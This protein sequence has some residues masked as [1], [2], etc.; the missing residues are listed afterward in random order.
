MQLSKKFVASIPHWYMRGRAIYAVIGEGRQIV[1]ENSGMFR[2]DHR[3]SD[4]TTISVRAN[5]DEA[6]SN[7]PLASSGQYLQG[8]Q[9]LTFSPVNS[10]IELLHVFSSTLVHEFKFGFNR[11]TVDTD[12]INQTAVLYAFAVSGFTTLNNNKQSM[13]TGN[14]LSEI[15]NVTWVKGRHTAKAGAEIRRIQLNQGNTASGTVNFASQAAFAANQVST[16]TLTGVLP[17]N[18]LRKTQYFG[19]LQ[20]EFKW[21]PNLTVNLGARYSFFNIFHEVLANYRSFPP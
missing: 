3:F 7:A 14:S 19:Y 1:S 11:S 8:Q 17:V 12:N 16:A 13:G 2:I 5:I 15:D 10:V 6:V 20:D 18:G 9:Q 4:K 21:L